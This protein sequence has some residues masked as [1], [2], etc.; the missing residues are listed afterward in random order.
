M[1][2]RNIFWMEWLFGVKH[3]WM[4]LDWKCLFRSMACF[5]VCLFGIDHVSLEL[6]VFGSWVFGLMWEWFGKLAVLFLSGVLPS[7]ISANFWLL[8]GKNLSIRVGF[9]YASVWGF[10]A[11]AKL[12]TWDSERGKS[13]QQNKGSEWKKIPAIELGF[14]VVEI[15]VVELG[16]WAGACVSRPIEGNHPG[17]QTPVGPRQRNDVYTSV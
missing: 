1:Y 11:S 10:D 9:T 8:S 13:L 17:V 7:M 15:P 12:W 14:R 4:S 16:S 5:T 3:I 6:E 2:W